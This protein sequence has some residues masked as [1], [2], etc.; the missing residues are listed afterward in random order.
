MSGLHPELSRKSVF[1]PSTTKLDNKRHS[2][3]ETGQIWPL[4]G[5]EGGFSLREN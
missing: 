3:V 1:Q 5:L 2:T 4:D